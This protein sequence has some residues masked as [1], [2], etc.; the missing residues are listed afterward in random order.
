MQTETLTQMS[1]ISAVHNK[2]QTSS[3]TQNFKNKNEFWD[4]HHVTAYEN[5]PHTDV[6]EGA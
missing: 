2:W 3:N 5:V 4:A 1:N 6:V